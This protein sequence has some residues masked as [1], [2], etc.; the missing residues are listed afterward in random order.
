MLFNQPEELDNQL[1]SLLLQH[2]FRPSLIPERN[3]WPQDRG[4]NI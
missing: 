4:L 1:I 2:F 3:T